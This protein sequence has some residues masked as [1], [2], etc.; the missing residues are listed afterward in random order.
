MNRLIEIKIWLIG[1]LLFY[2]SGS[3]QNTYKNKYN[4]LNP[5]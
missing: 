4:G 3:I 1:Y 5:A 2:F